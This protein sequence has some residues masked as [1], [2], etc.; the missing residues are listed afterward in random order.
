MGNIQA[1][2]DILN[3]I[4][5]VAAAMQPLAASSVAACCVI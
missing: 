3:L 2:V 4:Q 1:M 5:L